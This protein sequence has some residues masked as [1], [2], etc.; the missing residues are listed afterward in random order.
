MM[1][2][3]WQGNTYQLAPSQTLHT[4]NGLNMAVRAFPDQACV[5]DVSQ[6]SEMDSIGVAALVN[7]YRQ[8]TKQGVSLAIHGASDRIARLLALYG[9]PFPDP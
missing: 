4:L 6:V 1:P 5:L 9:L 3:Q 8:A 2:G 7:L